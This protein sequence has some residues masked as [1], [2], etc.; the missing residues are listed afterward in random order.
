[1]NPHRT[2][3]PYCLQPLRWHYWPP[4]QESCNLGK[5]YCLAFYYR[6]SEWHISNQKPHVSLLIMYLTNAG[7]KCKWMQGPLKVY[8]FDPTIGNWLNL[9]FRY[10]SHKAWYVIDQTFWKTS[11][12]SGHCNQKPWLFGR[13][14]V[15]IKKGIFAHFIKWSV[16][17]LVSSRPR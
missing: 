6:I 8:I 14:C 7:F 12:S 5:Q 15:G 3:I 16:G 11:S 9:P 2:E 17:H 10:P 4:I 1:M 13:K